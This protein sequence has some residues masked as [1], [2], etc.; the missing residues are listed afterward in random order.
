MMFFGGVKRMVSSA[1]ILVSPGSSGV[2]GAGG[3]VWHET[4]IAKSSRISIFF[5]NYF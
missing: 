5:I 2:G 3:F 4:A 1:E